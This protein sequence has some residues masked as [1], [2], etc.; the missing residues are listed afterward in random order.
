MPTGLWRSHSLRVLSTIL[1]LQNDRTN[2]RDLEK[3]RLVNYSIM[4]RTNSLILYKNQK[5]LTRIVQWDQSSWNCNESYELN[6]MAT[7]QI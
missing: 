3:L 7:S 6:N 1:S 2:L 4:F 5:I